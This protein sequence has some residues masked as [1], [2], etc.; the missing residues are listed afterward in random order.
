MSLS[1][2]CHDCVEHSQKL[3]FYEQRNRQELEKLTLKQLQDQCR[4]FQLI[5]PEDAGKTRLIDILLD[6]PEYRKRIRQ[7]LDI[8]GFIPYQYTPLSINKR[9]DALSQI[10]T[11]AV[12]QTAVTLIRQQRNILYYRWVLH[13]EASQTGPCPECI[14][15]AGI[16][17]PSDPRPDIPAHPGC[18]CEWE[19]EYEE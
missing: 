1:C 9:V 10:F 6:S 15:N 14:A 19:V 18:V 11:Y 13:P 17:Y 4:F 12:M 8:D 5:Y 3:R 7:H 16:Y 2:D